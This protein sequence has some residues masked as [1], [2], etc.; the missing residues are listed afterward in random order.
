MNE[1]NDRPLFR[2]EKRNK[3]LISKDLREALATHDTTIIQQRIFF[4]ILS[5]LKEKQSHFL[6][7]KSTSPEE[8]GKLLSFNDYYDGFANE[9][10][11]QFQIPMKDINVIPRRD[12][13]LKRKIR[14]EVIHEALVELS[15]IK[16]FR[17][18]DNS[19]KGYQ[20]VFFILNPKWNSRYVYFT[21]DKA[22]V[23]ILFNLKPFF[24]VKSD[25]PNLAST[26]NTLRFLLLI[27]KYRKIGFFKKS[28]EKLLKE[29]NIPLKRYHFPSIFE[30]DFLMPVKAD[31]DS[32]NDISFNYS[33]CKGEFSITIYPTKYS[34]GLHEEF[35]SAEDLKI[36]RALKYLK[37][38]R[39]LNE[40][41]VRIIE[42]L[43][44]VQGYD[45]LA[46]RIKRRIDKNLIGDEFINA[47]FNLI[48]KL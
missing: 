10:L 47:I 19:I 12:S 44:K 11:I 8:K 13:S 15:T 3:I 2:P 46:S 27:I 36:H 42:K 45:A 25:L 38:S 29:L 1:M 43:Y 18:K 30:R 6:S 31:L 14:N 33:Q 7:L 35:T 34:V 48:E 26:P 39:N 23:G 9:G 17:L 28:F 16:S 20:A 24:Q 41:N 40:K 21:V 22:V 4:I 5:A 37:K 32:L